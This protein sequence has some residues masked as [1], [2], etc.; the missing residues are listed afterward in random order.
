MSIAF[1]A[2]GT[3]PNEYVGDM[4]FNP[5]TGP[6]VIG[7]VRDTGGGTD[8]SLTYDGHRHHR[9]RVVHVGVGPVRWLS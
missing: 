5:L 7:V 1:V 3:P 9:H 8:A 6:F 2:G 4:S